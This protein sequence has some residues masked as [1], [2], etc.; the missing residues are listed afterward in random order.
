MAIRGRRFVCRE[1]EGVNVRNGIENGV[2][3]T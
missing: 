1:S 2:Y 3:K